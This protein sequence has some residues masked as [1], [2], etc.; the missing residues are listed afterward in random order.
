MKSFILLFPC[1]VVGAHLAWASTPLSTVNSA[2]NQPPSLLLLVGAVGAPEFDDTFREQTSLWLQAAEMAGM[3]T[4]VIG[5]RDESK[6]GTESQPESE[7]ESKPTTESTTELLL[8]DSASAASESDL[9]RAETYFKN[10]PS[11]GE[12]PLWVVFIGHGTFDGR[13]ARFNLRGPDL[14]ATTV[15]AWLKPFTRPVVVIQTASASS[16]F[17]AALS[18]PGR[19]IITAT[20]SGYEQNYTRFGTYFAKAIHDPVADLDG[21]AQ[22]SVLEAFLAASA[23][24]I[25]F[26][27]SEGRLATEHALLDD[28]GDGMGTPAEWYRG[29]RPVKKSQDGTQRDGFRAHQIHLLPSADEERWS[30][31]QRKR[32]DELELAVHQLR[33][34]HTGSNAIPSEAHW[35]AL[36]RLLVDLA[37]LHEEVDAT[38]A[39]KSDPLEPEITNPS[40][41]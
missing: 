8:A 28:N 25:D 36:E 24:V 23:G 20:R 4:H 16:P 38:H 1:L 13:E 21:D 26:Y 9:E 39:D 17:L 6:A 33:E 31:V 10:E 30:P 7:P 18:R 22:V 29:L 14:P 41:P 2:T 37:L 35:A 19:T 3:H 32:R 15:E 11:A 27:K 34:R 5:L 12:S 40:A